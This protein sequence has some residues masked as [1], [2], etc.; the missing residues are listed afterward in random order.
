MSQD[1]PAENQVAVPDAVLTLVRWGDGLLVW[2]ENPLF[3]GKAEEL[4]EEFPL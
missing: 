3:L 1:K 4:S 2:R